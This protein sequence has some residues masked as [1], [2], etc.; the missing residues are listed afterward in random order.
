ML[1]QQMNDGGMG[2][3]RT[4]SIRADRML[5]RIVAEGEFRD[6]DGTPVFVAINEDQYGEL[7]ELDVWKAD[8]SP[9]IRIPE[10]SQ[11]EIKPG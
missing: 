5:G 9:L 10:A 2:S 11:I 1:V 6:A 7:F 3:L 8:F 4:C